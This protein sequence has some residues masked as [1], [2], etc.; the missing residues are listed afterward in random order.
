MKC[1]IAVFSLGITCTLSFV[2]NAPGSNFYTLQSS[3]TD[4]TEALKP[5]ATSTDEP[6]FEDIDIEA[7]FTA[8]TFPIKPD[9]LI[10]KAKDFFFEKKAGT[11]DQSILD[12][13]FVFR[14]AVVETNREDF[15]KALESFKL[16]D[17]FDIRSSYF[18]W[19]VDPTQHNRVYVFNRQKGTLI[20]P[21]MGAQPTGKVLELPPQCFH[22]DFTEGGLVKEFGFYT[23]DR[24]QG[25]TGGLGGVFGY[26]YGVGRPL[27]FPEG[28]PYRKSF[29]R[30]MVESLA[31]FLSKFSRK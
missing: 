15:I 18:G 16:E 14:A 26:F 3:P 20:A 13:S 19:T 29:R 6:K 5:L 25:N 7:A 17:S 2:P 1:S 8:S 22:V 4:Q 30:R 9:D 27:P 10:A 28:K 31:N 11:A 24:A 21:F 23:V 12:D